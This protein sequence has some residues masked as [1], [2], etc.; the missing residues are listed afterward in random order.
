MAKSSQI[1]GRNHHYWPR[2]PGE[3]KLG[4]RTLMVQIE[5]LRWHNRDSSQEIKG[6]MRFSD[7]IKMQDLRLRI[8][9]RMEQLMF[10]KLASRDP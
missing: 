9:L 4:E 7:G 6:K 2:F 10:R 8:S 5:K 3:M 1:D